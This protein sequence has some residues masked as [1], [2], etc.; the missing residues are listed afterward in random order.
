MR[1]LY[2]LI[3]LQL[4]DPH[5]TQRVLSERR[6]AI[7]PNK[8]QVCLQEKSDLDVLVFAGAESSDGWGCVGGGSRQP[9]TR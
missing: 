9:R 7:G 2:P 5:D 3:H 1:R 8:V 6:L 4:R